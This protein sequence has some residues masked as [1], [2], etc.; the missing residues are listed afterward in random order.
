MR[1][2]QGADPAAQQQGGYAERGHAQ[3]ERGQADDADPPGTVLP[4]RRGAGAERQRGGGRKGISAASESI[5]SR[6][7]ASESP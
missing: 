7:S 4:L 2:G 5:G 1:G 6:Q 3:A